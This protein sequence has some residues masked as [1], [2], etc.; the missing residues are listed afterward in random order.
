MKM[1][2]KDEAAPNL[3]TSASDVDSGWRLTPESVL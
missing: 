1:M 3:P 2:E